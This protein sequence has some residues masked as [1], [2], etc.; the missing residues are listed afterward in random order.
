MLAAPGWVAWVVTDRGLWTAVAT[1]VVLVANVA[2]TRR[3]PSAKRWVVRTFQRLVI[4]PVVRV[5]LAIGVV[6]LGIC[7]LETTGRVSGQPRRTPVGEGR[8]GRTC[9]IVAEHGAAAGYVR[10]IEADPRVRIR[11]RTGSRL[12]P[13]WHDGTATVLY[14]DDPY[15]RQ[16]RICRW[17]PLRAYNAAVVRAMGTDLVT[18]RVDLAT[19]VDSSTGIEV[20]RY[21]RRDRNPVPVHG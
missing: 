14:D 16:R 18:V 3:W 6:P 19:C 7:L 15:A 13:T 8:V 21:G 10:N 2:L 17:H 12:R 11:L 5:L 20:C 1:S 9:W 4:N